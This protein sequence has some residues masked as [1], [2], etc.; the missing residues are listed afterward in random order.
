MVGVVWFGVL[1][2]GGSFFFGVVGGEW[3]GILFCWKVL[4]K[5]GESG[6]NK[7]MDGADGIGIDVWGWGWG[8]GGG[9]KGGVL[10]LFVDV[11]SVFCFVV[12][13]GG[14]LNR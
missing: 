3:G 13:G 6:K 9:G 7:T 10:W 14:V 4:V 1:R 12:F 5:H 8:G 11:C 2:G